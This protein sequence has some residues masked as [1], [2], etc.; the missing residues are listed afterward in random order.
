MKKTIT[1]DNREISLKVNG[2]TLRRY[3]RVYGRDPLADFMA[4]SDGL[5]DIDVVYDFFYLMAKT[6]APELANQDEFFESFDSLPV[7]ELF[8]S[9]R[10][11]I[12]AT[13]QTTVESKKK[14]KH[15]ANQ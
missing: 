7:L 9:I 1:I 10:P 3:K 12:E 5:I 2:N 15:P 4:M 13:I 14:S 8:E 6:A 11:L